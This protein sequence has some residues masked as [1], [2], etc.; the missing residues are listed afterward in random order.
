MRR[1]RARRGALAPPPL[2][3]GAGTSPAGLRVRT[4]ATMTTSTVE[5]LADSLGMQIEDVEGFARARYGDVPIEGE[6]AV[7]V[8]MD[9]DSEHCV[10]SVPEVWWPGADPDAGSG[11]T[12]MR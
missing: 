3:P 7:A 10:R 4:M 6:V 11:A 12:L 9:L 2:T 1:V 8:R 5:F